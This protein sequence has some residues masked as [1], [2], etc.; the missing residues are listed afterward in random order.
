M[1]LLVASLVLALN[2]W[3]YC[4]MGVFMLVSRTGRAYPLWRECVMHLYPSVFRRGLLLAAPSH[5]LQAL[6]LGPRPHRGAQTN[7]HG[8]EIMG[9]AMAH[10]CADGGVD[11]YDDPRDRGG[12]EYGEDAEA[13]GGG[14]AVQRMAAMTESHC[15]T[16]L[17][18][19]RLLGYL[20][21]VV[22]VCRLVS[23]V[24]W[25]CGYMYLGL[26]TCLAE[27]GMLCHELLLHETMQI[28]RAMGVLMLNVAVSLVYIGAGLPSCRG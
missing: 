5:V 11:D 9:D 25:G 19:H 13:R 24:R 14:G 12:E 28:H 1:S 3:L 18:C 23:S 10:V 21:C 8:D 16:R 27:M 15:E 2:G 6:C 20:L 22:G 17:L 7:R 4:A 26:A